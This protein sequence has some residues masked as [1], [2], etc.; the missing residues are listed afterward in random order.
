MKIKISPEIQEVLDRHRNNQ[1]RPNR[2]DAISLEDFRAYMPMHNYVFTP[3]RELWPAASVNARIPPKRIGTDENNKPIFMAA[4]TWLDKNQPVEQMTWA[5]GEPMLIEDRL[6]SEGGWIERKGPRI[7]PGSAV[8]A[9]PWLDHVHKVYPNDTDHIVK[10]FAH[11]KQRPQDKINHAILFG[12]LQGIGKDT[13][14]EPVKRAVGPWNFAEVSP[15]ILLGR[16]NGY[17]KSVILRVNEAR[18]LGD[19]NRFTLCDHMKAIT[20]APPDVLRVDEKFLREYNVPKLLRCPYHDKPYGRHI[21]ARRRPQALC[22][23]VRPDQ[24]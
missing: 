12:G 8:A 14:I 17:L 22:R 4:S 24:G 18:D 19:I 6:I 5:P 10:W 1:P 16:F 9:G 20:A 13:L 3:T 23:L 11:R 21:P 15:H 2:H 7:E